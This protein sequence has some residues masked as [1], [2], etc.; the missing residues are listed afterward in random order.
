[1][2]SHIPSASPHCLFSVEMVGKA[3]LGNRIPSG[4]CCTGRKERVEEDSTR[5]PPELGTPVPSSNCVPQD[6]PGSRSG[7]DKGG[8]RLEA[9][10]RGTHLSTNFT[11]PRER[12]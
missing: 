3:G 7:S 4:P 12:G 10:S 1:M 9:S 6:N 11:G 8:V 2:E 5:A